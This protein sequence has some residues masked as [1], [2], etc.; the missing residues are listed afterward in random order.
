[1]V[2]RPGE[3]DRVLAGHPWIYAGSVLRLA[4]AAEDGSVVQVKD[5]RHRFLGVGFYNS[6]SKINVRLIDTERVEINR[7]Y[8]EKRIREA[9][10]LRKRAMPRASSQMIEQSLALRSGYAL[11]SFSEA[12]LISEKRP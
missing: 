4:G 9:L 5:H 10:E 11:P 8:L 2:L 7:G 3:A 12:R 6:K 1:M